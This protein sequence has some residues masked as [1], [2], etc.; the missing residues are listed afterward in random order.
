[1][2]C[3]STPVPHAGG[4][5]ENIHFFLKERLL[6]SELLSL[7]IRGLIIAQNSI[8]LFD[9]RGGCT[10]VKHPQVVNHIHLFRMSD[11]GNLN[12]AY[13]SWASSSPRTS[14][15]FSTTGEAAPS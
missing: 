8:P 10:I 12:G 1:M 5:R 13:D 3:P 2:A 14:S 9:Y 6:G 11:T 15:P 4:H 7:F